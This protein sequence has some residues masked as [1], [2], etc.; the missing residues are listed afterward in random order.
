MG[1][2]VDDSEAE[3]KTGIKTQIILADGSEDKVQD[4]SLPLSEEKIAAYKAELNEI[5]TQF[6]GYVRKGR[7]GKLTSDSVFSGKMYNNKDAVK[8]GLVDGI[9]SLDEAIKR[10]LKLAS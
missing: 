1:I 10:A 8:L 6:V 2:I 4:N 3:S 9:A 5:R 7:A